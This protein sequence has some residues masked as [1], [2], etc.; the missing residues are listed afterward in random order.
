V[1]NIYSRILSF[2]SKGSFKVSISA[3]LPERFI[4]R[5]ITPQIRNAIKDQP[6]VVLTGA[7]QVGKST[8]LTLSEPF[9]DWRYL[10]MDDFDTL[11]QARDRPE[12]LWVGTDKV[13][14][15]E[16]QK[17]PDLLPSIK[18]SVDRDPAQRKFILSGSANLLLMQQISESLAGR[19]VYITLHPF[20]LGE[21]ENKA[22]PDFLEQFLNQN[23]PDEGIQG[24][25]TP[26]PIGFLLRGF[27]PPLLSLP[28]PRSWNRWWEGYVAT[29]LERDLRQISQIDNLPDFRRLMELAALRTGQ[30]LN[31]SELARDASLSQPTAHRYVNLLQVTLLFER[32]PAFLKNRTS[33]LVKSPKAYWNDPGLPIFLSGI[34]DDEALRGTREIGFFFENL[35]FHHLRVLTDLM[36]PSARLYYWRTR[37]GKEVD[38]IVEHGRKLL[39]IETKLSSHVRLRDA[40]NLYAFLD[41][42]PEAAGGLILYNGNRICRLGEK[43]FAAPWYMITG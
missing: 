13:V 15:D 39:G 35:I 24:L 9:K 25:D 32:L 10:T 37:T 36:V 34:F 30:I 28:D 43:I 5:W 7:R 40:E 26:D 3:S 42:Y 1:N 6:I 19:A 18:V 38:F 21:I 4:S 14:I 2:F 12:E 17:V 22:P 11:I 8:L 29:Y 33:R 23:W 31:Q 20:T 41:E 27:L 16:V